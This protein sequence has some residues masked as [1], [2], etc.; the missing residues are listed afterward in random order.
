MTGQEKI[1][2]LRRSGRAPNRIQINDFGFSV[3]LGLDV[4]LLP[5]DVPEQ[6]DWRFTVGLLV[7]LSSDSAERM[8]RIAQSLAPYAKRIIATLHSA[9]PVVDGYGRKDFPIL[10]ITD[11][12]GAMTWQT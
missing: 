6:Q 2:A 9:V 4:F 3:N 12:A 5:Q 8:Q 10:K 7:T 11:T 1:L